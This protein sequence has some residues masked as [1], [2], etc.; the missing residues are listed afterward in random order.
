MQAGGESLEAALLLADKTLYTEAEEAARRRDAEDAAAAAAR[1]AGGG[2]GVGVVI[3]TAPTKTPPPLPEKKG[4]LFGG[5]SLLGGGAKAKATELPPATPQPSPAAAPL[6]ASKEAPDWLPLQADPQQAAR[7]ALA[8]LGRLTASASIHS[9]VGLLM[10]PGMTEALQRLNPLLTAAEAGEVERRVVTAILRFSRAGHISRTRQLVASLILLLQPAARGGGGGQEL[11]LE[12]LVTA[13][14]LKAEAVAG[15]L[16]TG[17]AY[18]DGG[19][20]D[21]RLLVFEFSSNFI[22][23]ASQVKLV[24][25]F[26]AAYKE[27]KSLCHQLIMGAGKTT[28]IAPVLALMLA[29]SKTA[30]TQVVPGALLEMTRSVMREKFS[31]LVQKP[32]YTFLF[33]RADA[34]DEAL[35]CKLEKARSS[36]AV[37]VASPTSIKSFVLKFTEILHL[38]DEHARNEGKVVA[39]GGGGSGGGFSFGGFSAM[40]GLSKAPVSEQ[41]S[42]SAEDLALFKKQALIFPKILRVF[43]TGV[44]LL[45]E[46]DLLLHPLKSELNW[47]L[48]KKQALDFTLP[49]TGQVGQGR[50]GMRWELAWHV[51]D[52][53]FFVSTGKTSG[54]LADS[55]AAKSTLAQL[56]A[57]VG[58]GIDKQVMQVTP[59]LVVLDQSFYHSALKPMFAQWLLIW[60]ADKGLVGMTKEAL[61]DYMLLGDKA[62]KPTLDLV[63]SKV[64]RSFTGT[65]VFALLVHQ[66]KY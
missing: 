44:L 4:G 60:L 55:A 53:L 20:Y 57:G 18:V 51:L 14:R 28:V 56:A 19:L 61:L 35:L 26:M 9:L 31:G 3:S 17:R 63:K 36:R 52:A 16:A 46:V 13:V 45:D 12:G 40:M 5:M 41:E 15:S 54:D 64:L 10:T 32:V 24:D 2:E 1:R 62:A 42:L 33:D 66:Y 43:Q 59:H 50:A 30:V 65:K 38:L 22:L 37:I 58:A 6:A 23:R 11:E 34:V 39:A 27:G 21:P 47:P 49:V 48:G 7:H 8:Q 29:T 25:K